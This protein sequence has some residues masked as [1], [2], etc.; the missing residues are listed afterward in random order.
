[1]SFMSE[2]NK[3]NTIPQKYIKKKK[4]ILNKLLISPGLTQD[5]GGRGCKKWRAE[6]A[7]LM[8]RV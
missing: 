3:V 8:K 2:S 7:N 4:S 1:M 6:Q 5:Y